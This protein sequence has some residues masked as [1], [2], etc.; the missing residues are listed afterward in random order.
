MKLLNRRPKQDDTPPGR[1]RPTATR[2]DTRPQAFSY[3]AQRSQTPGTGNTARAGSPVEQKQSSSEK[4]ILSGKLGLLVTGILGIATVLLLTSLSQEPQ[5]RMVG[6]ANQAYFMHDMSAY[7]HVASE[8]LGSSVLNRSK[9]SIDTAAIED[10]LLK[11]YPELSHASVGLSPFSNRAVIH[12]QP[13]KPAMVLSS[14]DNTAYLLD[15]NGRAIVSASDITDG[16]ELK[17]PTVLDKSGI[18]VERGVQALPGQVVTFVDQ[19]T[20]TLNAA[21]IEYGLLELPETA[22][23]LN[24]RLAGLPYYVKFNLQGDP[25]QQTGAFIAAKLRLDRD[26][27]TPSEYLDVRVPERAYYK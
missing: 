15:I 25:R 2:E 22:N 1:R 13:H 5:V 6:T 17:V 21:D 8:A 11:E 9:L 16:G 23:Q 18:R 26:R 19:V 4:S 14:I 10:S 27:A 3:Y 24:V 20:S 12:L 7:Q